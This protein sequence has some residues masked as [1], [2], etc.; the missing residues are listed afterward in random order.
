VTPDEVAAALA[1]PAPD[2]RLRE[3]LRAVLDD[4]CA[5]STANQGLHSWRCE[6]PD[7]REGPCRCVDLLLDDLVALAD[8]LVAVRATPPTD[9]LRETLTDW[10]AADGESWR[11]VAM[12]RDGGIVAAGIPEALLDAIIR[13]ATR[14]ETT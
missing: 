4:N 9:R 7:L 2:T 1:T 13:R 6:Y 12:D 3:R 14:E 5:T 10:Y 8:P 11:L